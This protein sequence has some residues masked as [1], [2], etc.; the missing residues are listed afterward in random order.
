MSKIED[1]Q[2]QLIYMSSANE[3]YSQMIM[4]FRK[5][6]YK[7]VEYCTGTTLSMWQRIYIDLISKI[8]KTDYDKQQDAINKAIKP[9]IKKR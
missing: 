3:R 5:H 7:L 6:P 9:Y 4:D 2:N 8:K 1:N